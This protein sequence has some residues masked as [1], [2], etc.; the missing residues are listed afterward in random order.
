MALT[1][2]AQT[3]RIVSIEEYLEYIG[4]E[5]DL[6]DEASIAASATMLKA[7][8]NDRQ[9]VLRQLNRLV[10]SQFRGEVSPSAQVIY[11]GRGKD[12]FVRANIWPS[13]ADVSSGRVYQDQFSYNLAHDHNYSFMTVGYYGPGYVTEIHEYDHDRLEGVIGEPVEMR[14]LERKLFSTGMVMLYRA[15]RDLHIQL[16][17]DDLSITLNLMISTPEVQ[18]RD[19]YFFDLQR[20]TLSGFPDEADSSRRIAVIGMAGHIGD[21]N[22]SQLLH[23]LSLMH[24]CRR[25]RLTA[26]ESLAQL[27]PRDAGEIWSRAAVDAAPAVATAARRHLAALEREAASN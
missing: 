18:A 13:L 4:R 9:L 16:P 17:P 21:P 8:S 23:D 14:F 7:L 3:D 15:N 22:T 24:P 6:R 1:L 19:Q 2:Q 27:S 26:F 25:T 10:K 12:F 11:L 20:R 5:V